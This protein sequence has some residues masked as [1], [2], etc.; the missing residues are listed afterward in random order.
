MFTLGDNLERRRH[1]SETPHASPSLF[2]FFRAVFANYS[3]PPALTSRCFTPGILSSHPMT[4][5]LALHD[6]QQGCPADENLSGHGNDLPSMNPCLLTR[7]SQQSTILVYVVAPIS[8]RPSLG[9]R[10]NSHYET[11]AHRRPGLKNRAVVQGAS[12][13]PCGPC[14]KL[15][16]PVLRT[17]HEVDA[18]NNPSHPLMFFS[19][20]NSINYV[21]E[22]L[23]YCLK[24]TTT[25]QLLHFCFHPHLQCGI[26]TQRGWISPSSKYTSYV[27]LFQ[28]THLAANLSPLLMMFLACARSA[29]DLSVKIIPLQPRRKA[30]KSWPRLDL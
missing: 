7:S 1:R 8:W 6:M 28:S 11:K 12:S 19:K 26:A 21:F 23:K 9:A 10:A 22:S 18:R 14:R 24:L 17:N 27:P 16:T 20:D 30:R 25:K 15:R 5:R 4:R 3:E 29:D 2:G 13:A